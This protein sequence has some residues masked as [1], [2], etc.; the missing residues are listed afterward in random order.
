MAVKWN[1]ERPLQHMRAGQSFYIPCND[2]TLISREIKKIA[3]ELAIDVVVRRVYES[4]TVGTRV[5]KVK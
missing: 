5:W 4:D 3:I 1:L 2:G